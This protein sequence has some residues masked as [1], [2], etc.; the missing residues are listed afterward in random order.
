MIH[1]MDIALDKVREIVTNEEWILIE[2]ATRCMQKLHA[3]RMSLVT[4]T[5]FTDDAQMKKLKKVNRI[6]NKSKLRIER[7]L[8][9]AMNYMEE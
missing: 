7:R 1:P 2:Q 8:Y 4:P 6:Y 9:D 3:M 5:L